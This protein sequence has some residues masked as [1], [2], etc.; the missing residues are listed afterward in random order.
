MH[1]AYVLADHGI[2][3]FGEKGA[4][5]HVQSSV[6]AMC[7]LGHEVQVL[8]ARLGSPSEGFPAR[9]CKVQ[10]ESEPCSSPRTLDERGRKELRY[11]AI[12][13]AME[14][15]LKAAVG[16]DLVYERYSLWSAAGVRAARVLGVP[17]VVEINAPLI[18]EQQRYRRL[19][20][21][22]LARSLELEVL[23]GA[24]LIVAVSAVLREC[25]I[26]RG[27]PPE[28]VIVA[29]NG[30]DCK[31]YSNMQPPRRG[32]ADD[33]RIGFVGSLKSW[34]GIEILLDAFREIASLL[35]RARLIV[36][37]DGPLRGWIEGY[38]RGAG[39]QDSVEI[40]GWLSHAQLPAALSRVDVALAPY[41]ALDRF[42]F[43]PLK[44]FDY[45]AAG[46]PIVASNL[47]QVAEIVSHERNALL[48]PAGEVMALADAVL[49]IVRD[50][51]LA[52]RLA[53][54]ARRTALQHDWLLQTD[55]ILAH[56][57]IRYAPR[58]VRP[59]A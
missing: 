42:Y 59:V 16:V 7:A 30:V 37:G 50:V 46:R 14:A 15:R 13:E 21:E 27:A 39:L 28:R 4:C 55:R 41:P 47:G 26:E 25:L 32:I 58:A 45:L 10:P 18:E 29:P 54:E 57:P 5:V 12:A 20:H 1:I 2:P 34:H 24:D 48:V 43:S 35:P 31:A 40:T 11:M 49:R 38:A 33:P 36:T 19:V 51:Q 23:Q 22:S 8:A 52:T 9:Y 6:G 17:C 53:G 44:L 56:D 3:L